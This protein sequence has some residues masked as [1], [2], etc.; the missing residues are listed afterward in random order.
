MRLGS[1]L[2]AIALAL[3]GASNALATTT[4]CVSTTAQLV[5]KL[6]F[7]TTA[8]DNVEI[9]LVQG[10]Y[11][12]TGQWISQFAADTNSVGIALKG[13]YSACGPG[14]TAGTRSAKVDANNTVLDGATTGRLRIDYARSLLVD[15]M[16]IQRYGGGVMLGVNEYGNGTLSNVIARD[17]AVNGL[18]AVLLI[19]NGAVLVADSLFDGNYQGS[20]CSVA[21]CAALAIQASFA[22]I[23]NTTI[24]DNP[25]VNGLLIDSGSG[26][27]DGDNAVAVNDIF[28]NNGADMTTNG[29]VGLTVSYSDFTVKSG[30]V[31]VG[32]GNIATDPLFVDPGHYDYALTANGL[33]V[34]PAVNTGASAAAMG[35]LE[36]YG[37]PGF[38][39]A[40]NPRIVG[41]NIDMG[42]FESAWDDRH[43]FVVTSSADTGAGTLRAAITAA[44][45]NPGA[46]HIT[47]NIPGGCGQ[48]IA[49]ASALPA[50][51]YPLTI[52]ATTQPGWAPNTL[53]G[54]FDATLCVS[55]IT[56]KVGI[57]LDA[58][59]SG[60]SLVVHGIVF[61]GFG[62]SAIRLKAGS[63]HEISGNE[64]IGSGFVGTNVYA[65]TVTGTTSSA[66]IGVIGNDPSQIE[67][68][69]NHIANSSIAGVLLSNAAGGTT[70]A[71]NLFG[72][73]ADGTAPAG[74]TLG[75]YMADSP[76]NI[77]RANYIGNSTYDAIY[78][79][80]VGSHGNVV[81]QNQIGWDFYG[82][83]PNGRYGVNVDVGAHD[84]RIGASGLY[85]TGF[86]NNIRNSAVAGVMMEPGTG[87]GN[88]V[89]GNDMIGN[90][91]PFAGLAID[92][93]VEGRTANTAYGA[94]NYPLL[95]NSFAMPNRQLVT[96]VLDAA[97]NT[98]YRF[99][100]YHLYT[101]PHDPDVGEGGLF[102]GEFA[103][104]QTDANGHCAFLISLTQVQVGGYL[105]AT[106]TAAGGNTS[107]IGNAVSD[108]TEGIF[109]DGFGGADAC[110]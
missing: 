57:G 3:I 27:F 22:E 5:A 50:I 79:G 68:R 96:G 94:Q 101:T 6:N 17:N 19:S 10:V 23:N 39:I 59:G 28:W 53:V 26:N 66:L 18:A 43:N 13:G 25:S 7:W 49:L 33:Q 109:I 54:A 97:P 55:L 78:L 12:L 77:V 82:D 63:G 106:A 93:G 102:S 37:Y 91:G 58:T 44:N 14:G 83:M 42:A 31:A 76:Y 52:D 65:V 98:Q 30:N 29:D 74:N 61:I 105:S 45:A 88:Y 110:Q 32:A 11:D 87:S 24:V 36:N 20:N 67:P 85:G 8:T 47:F 51:Q 95:R 64:F 35:Q 2:S 38:D 1:W 62:N 81:Q 80:G 21:Y 107:E 16:A 75:I 86:S 72:V 84:N 92:F 34:S 4:V 46:S 103:T 71:N 56:N 69:M 89:L 100:F 41:S 15:G 104:L 9:Q 60:S 70:V 73:G 99:D 48:I 108:Q 90:G 40:G